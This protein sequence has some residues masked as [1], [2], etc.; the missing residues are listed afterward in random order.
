[1]VRMVSTVTVRMS[2]R[3]TYRLAEDTTPEA[4]K[5]LFR[6]LSTKT[7]AEKLRM[8]SK[9]NATLRNLTM[10]RLR[11]RYPNES[12]LELKIRLA[13]FLFGRQMSESFVKRL[14]AS[15]LHE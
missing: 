11:E 12:S 13:E 14:I 9:Q 1:M 2:I 15:Q 10:I 7:P 3:Y 5:V 4:E 8:V 6:L